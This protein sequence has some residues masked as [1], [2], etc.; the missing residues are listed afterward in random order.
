MD[1]YRIMRHAGVSTTDNNKSNYTWTIMCKKKM[2]IF[3]ISDCNMM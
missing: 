2:W 1:V 3:S